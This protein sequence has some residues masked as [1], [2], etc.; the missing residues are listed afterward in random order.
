MAT[1]ARF[2]PSASKRW[3][4]CPGSLVLNAGRKDDGPSPYADK[5]TAMHAVAAWCLTEH[6]RASKRVGDQIPVHKD[7]EEPRHVEFTDDMATDTQEY[8][9]W[10]RSFAIGKVLHVEQQVDFSGV[11]GQP[12]QFG[13]ADAIVW[14]A[15]S[16]EL[17]IV[18]LKTGFRPVDAAGNTQLMTYAL[19]ALL[20]LTAAGTSRPAQVEEQPEPQAEEQQQEAGDDDLF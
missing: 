3:L 1:H 19:G 17:T 6:Y 12:D 4:S 18:D 11:V 7:G 9:D 13:T 16:G 15:E 5:G 14:D 20:Q 8:V 10:L 2:S